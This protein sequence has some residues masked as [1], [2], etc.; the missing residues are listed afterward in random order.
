MQLTED[1]KRVLVSTRFS[2]I[3]EFLDR[4]GHGSGNDIVGRVI[5]LS[6]DVHITCSLGK[7]RKSHPKWSQLKELYEKRDAVVA[8]L[9][10]TSYS[11]EKQRSEIES[12]NQQIDSLLLQVDDDIFQQAKILICFAPLLIQ[13][14][15]QNRFNPDVQIIDDMEIF[16]KSQCYAVISQVCLLFEFD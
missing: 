15:Y 16:H 3:V 13:Q 9:Q 2:N 4:C 10:S 8:Q 7:T 5:T 6:N 1:G 14:K 12:L 11:N